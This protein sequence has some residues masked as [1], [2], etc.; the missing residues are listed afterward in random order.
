MDRA[1]YIQ[2]I[3]HQIYIEFLRN[4]FSTYA[5]VLFRYV[6]LFL[7]LTFFFSVRRSFTAFGVCV[8]VASF[9]GNDKSLWT[10]LE[11]WV[12]MDIEI[13][14]YIFEIAYV[15]FMYMYVKEMLD[16]PTC[17]KC[18]FHRAP[19]KPARA[20]GLCVIFFCWWTSHKSLM[21]LFVLNTFKAVRYEFL[22]NKS[23]NGDRNKFSKFFLLYNKASRIRLC[24]IIYA[25]SPDVCDENIISAKTGDF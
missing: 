8:C 23:R 5:H 12:M 4:I 18:P 24:R 1:A 10:L 14:L 22:Y 6:L 16:P 21:L 11:G 19:F 13:F 15:T 17:I 9:E 7:F 3:Y 2:N 25:V 20:E